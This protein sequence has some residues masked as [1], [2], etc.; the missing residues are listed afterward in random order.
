MKVKVC[1]LFLINA[2]MLVIGNYSFY[3]LVVF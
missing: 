3:G 1:D 2:K